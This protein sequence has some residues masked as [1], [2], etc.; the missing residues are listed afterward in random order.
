MNVLTNLIILLL[1]ISPS[2][3]A[4]IWRGI[5][6]KPENRCSEY[7]SDEYYYPQQVELEIIRSM[8][9]LVYSPYNGIT[10]EDRYDTDIEHIVAR[11]E[12]HD[13]GLCSASDATK[14]QFSRDILNLTLAE[15]TLNRNY[16][17]AKDAAQ[18]LPQYNQ[19]WFAHRIVQVK[20]KYNL[21]VDRAEKNALEKVLSN[22]TST[23]LVYYENTDS[24]SNI[25]KNK[26]TSDDPVLKQYDDNKNGRITCKEARR[27]GIAP[28]PRSHPAYKYMHDGD[29]D[30][31]VCE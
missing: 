11:S 14:A 21:S 9:G 31:T 3:Y 8:N 6:V 5:E 30:G 17:K 19:C 18:W 12:A 25:N 27:H 24:R 26:T 28:V 7:N 20:Q 16:K 15:P 13:S 4:E 22:C 10:Y 23:Q 2:S 29:N 1:L